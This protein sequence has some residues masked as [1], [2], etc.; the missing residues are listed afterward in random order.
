M[1]YSVYTVGYLHCT[2]PTMYMAMVECTVYRHIDILIP[3]YFIQTTSQCVCTQC[4]GRMEVKR[5]F[6]ESERLMRIYMKR[7]KT[8]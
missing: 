1:D 5:K 8:L 2:L 4:V 7:N 6:Y 3:D